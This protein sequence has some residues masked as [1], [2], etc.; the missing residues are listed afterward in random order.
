[1]NLNC[2]SQSAV[3][4]ILNSP[5][6][7]SFFCSVFLFFLTAFAQVNFNEY[8]WRW[9]IQILVI[10]CLY[11]SKCLK[12]TQCWVGALTAAIKNKN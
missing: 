11:C 6:V 10:I 12:V 2:L 7:L 5:L 4:N 9:S 1:M 3:S 8:L